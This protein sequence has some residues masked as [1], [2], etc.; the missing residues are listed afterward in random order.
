MSKSIASYGSWRSPITGDLITSNVID[1]GYLEVDGEDIYWLETRPQEGG[2]MVIARRRPDGEINFLTPEPFNVRSRVHEYGGGAYTISDGVVYFSNFSDN[3]IY[4]QSGDR[5]PLALTPESKRRYADMVV[6]QKRGLIYCVVED[7]SI[8]G[9]EAENYLAA[10]DLVSGEIAFRLADGNDFYS[11][12]TFSPDGSQAAWLT[13]HHPNMPWEGCELWLSDLDEQGHAISNTKI[14]GGQEESIV[15]PE[16]SPGGELFFISDRS[17]WWNIFTWKDDESWP[18][19]EMEV[20]FCR[21]LWLFRR[22]SYG[23]FNDT[24]IFSIY[25]Q[26]GFW[27]LGKLNLESGS[28]ETIDT[29]L[30]DFYTFQVTPEG[31]VLSGGGPEDF[32]GIHLY[33]PDEDRWHTLKSASGLEIDGGY[34]SRPVSY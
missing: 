33:R 10:V 9:P 15:Q 21:P 3:R 24:T 7:H 16:W 17:G 6:D 2:R 23:F 14:A 22:K 31:V 11:S 30:T 20:E 13:W 19:I 25:T 1:L 12:L 8:E 29:Q 5:E 18:I 4:S 27:Y 32:K 34:L 28:I 26:G